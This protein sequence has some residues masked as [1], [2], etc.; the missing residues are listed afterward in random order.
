MKVRMKELNDIMRNTARAYHDVAARLGIS[1]CAFNILYILCEE[2]EGCRQ[3]V[4]YKKSGIGKTTVNSAIRKMER[5]GLIYLLPGEGRNTCIF[6]TDAGRAF[7]KEKIEPVIQIENEIMDSM[8]QEE[9]TLFLDLNRR[10][11]LEFTKRAS[12]EPGQKEQD[13]HEDHPV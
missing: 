3:S 13:P 4:L 12:G 10:F 8:P 2:G 6:L 11:Y 9:Q 1:A 5:Q 7:L